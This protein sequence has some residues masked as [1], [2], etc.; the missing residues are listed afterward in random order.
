MRE[1][2]LGKSLEHEKRDW[3]EGAVSLFFFF[4]PFAFQNIFLK[5]L[6]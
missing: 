1:N 4:V 2:P 3:L 6:N 5:K